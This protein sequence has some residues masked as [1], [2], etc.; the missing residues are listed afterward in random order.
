V[1]WLKEMAM[2]VL[3]KVGSSNPEYSGGCDYA[4][5]EIDEELAKLMLRRITGLCE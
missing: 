3:P 4:A 1:R 2:Q 5:V